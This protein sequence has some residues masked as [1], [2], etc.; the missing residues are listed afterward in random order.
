MYVVYDEPL[1]ALLLAS[2]DAK[3]C[4]VIDV[5][6]EPPL[7]L[8]SNVGVI[9]PGFVVPVDVSASFTL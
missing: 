2:P 5:H 9:Y 1:T 7:V 3:Y 6:E 8:Y 4:E